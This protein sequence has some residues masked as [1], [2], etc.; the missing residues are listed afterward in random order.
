MMQVQVQVQKQVQKSKNA[1]PSAFAV[2]SLVVLSH[3]ALLSVGIGQLSTNP[4]VSSIA[5]HDHKI[6]RIQFVFTSL[7]T[8]VGSFPS[9]S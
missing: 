9:L 7:V 1:I 4:Q 6:V 8:I 3:A 5:L 2:P